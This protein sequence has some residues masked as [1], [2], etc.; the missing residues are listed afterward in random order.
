MRFLLAPALSVEVVRF[1][2]CPML[3][4]SCIPLSCLCCS[5]WRGDRYERK[6]KLLERRF[7]NAMVAWRDAGLRR[8]E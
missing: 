7:K 4:V 2:F 1:L 6:L 5:D 3:G 8:V